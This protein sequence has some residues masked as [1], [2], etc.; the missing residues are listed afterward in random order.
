ME[1]IGSRGSA[2]AV[3][4]KRTMKTNLVEELVKELNID[5]HGAHIGKFIGRH[6]EENLRAKHIVLRTCLA[7]FGFQS[8]QSQLEYGKS[9]GVQ[10]GVSG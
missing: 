10:Q 5:E 4:R 2:R 8:A 6:I 7:F 3:E 1:T 9:V